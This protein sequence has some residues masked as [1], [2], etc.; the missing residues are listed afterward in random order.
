MEWEKQI[1]GTCEQKPYYKMEIP[2]LKVTSRETL[3]IMKGTIF[4]LSFFFLSVF[5]I[6]L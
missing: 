5:F 3:E 6:L 2:K 4:S 1:C